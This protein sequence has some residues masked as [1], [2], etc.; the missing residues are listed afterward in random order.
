MVGLIKDASGKATGV[1][2]LDKVT[3]EK[4]EVKV[5]VQPSRPLNPLPI[6]LARGEPMCAD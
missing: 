6:A 4:F 5:R 3:G 1:M 2:C